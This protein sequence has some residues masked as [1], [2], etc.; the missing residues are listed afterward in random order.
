MACNDTEEVMDRIIADKQY[1]QECKDCLKNPK[2]MDLQ[3][4]WFRVA[5]MGMPKGFIPDG[6]VSEGE[7]SSRPVS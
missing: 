2:T 4:A 1:H 5:L 3:P 6:K 7:P